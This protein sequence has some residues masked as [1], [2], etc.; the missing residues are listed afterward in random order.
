MTQVATL[1]VVMQICVIVFAVG[2]MVWMVIYSYEDKC[3]RP[4]G[5]W[6]EDWWKRKWRTRGER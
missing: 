2:V 3:G 6:L 1:I 4:M 5:K